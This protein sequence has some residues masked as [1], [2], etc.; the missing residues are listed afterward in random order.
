[1]KLKQKSCHIKG[2]NNF[3]IIVKLFIN[4]EYNYF[5]KYY[6]YRCVYININTC[7]YEKYYNYCY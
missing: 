6:Y 3:K 1:M 5:I 7:K 4:N 2:V